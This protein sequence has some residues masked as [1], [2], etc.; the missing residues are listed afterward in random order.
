M[1]LDIVLLD[2]SSSIFILG[3]QGK[4]NINIIFYVIEDILNHHKKF[5]F[6]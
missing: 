4:F 1:W 3:N 6:N 2:K 5:L